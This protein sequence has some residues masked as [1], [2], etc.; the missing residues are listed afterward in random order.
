MAENT[1]ILEKI[2]KLMA[3][4]QSTN[5]NEAALALKRARKLMDENNIT[6]QDLSLSQFVSVKQGAVRGLND[7]LIM[8]PLGRIIAH[9]FGLEMII[10]SRGG[11]FEALTF[12]GRAD[13]VESAMYVFTV[14]SRQTL[15]AKQEYLDRSRDLIE[16]EATELLEEQIDYGEVDIWDDDDYREYLK[17]RRSTVA[18]RLTK[19]Y[20]RGW[21]LSIEEK[22]E[23]FVLEEQEQKLLTQFVNKTFPNL[24]YSYSRRRSLDPSSW[25]AMNQGRADGKDGFE[26][27]RGVQGQ[28]RKRISGF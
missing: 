20:L 21:L 16:K 5:P 18:N 12:L 2:K 3:L 23:D 6:N 25:D 7:K 14:L 10:N 4:S 28:A 8:V 9:S 26:L 13:R 19:N 15:I 11:R 22:V 27:Y 24:T 1:E 17:R